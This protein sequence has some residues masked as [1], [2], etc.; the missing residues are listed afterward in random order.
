MN[1]DRSDTPALLDPI[2]NELEDGQNRASFP[3]PSIPFVFMG[4]GR[5]GAKFA[6]RVYGVPIRQSADP[7]RT[8]LEFGLI[9][10]MGIGDPHRSYFNLLRSGS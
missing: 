4:W 2:E 9:P 1:H 3:A 8:G 10:G 5:R 6:G 7:Q